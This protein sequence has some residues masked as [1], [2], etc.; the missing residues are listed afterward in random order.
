[1]PRGSLIVALDFSACDEEEF[2][3]WYDTE[4]FPERECV[5]GFGLCE[6][7]ISIANPKISVATYDLDSFDVLK[8]PAY[9]AISGE[10]LSPWSRR[11]G[12]KYKRLLRSDGDQASHGN[13]EAR[14]G[15]GGLLINAMNVAPEHEADFNAW[16]DQ[17]HLSALAKV[18][19]TILARRFKSRSGSHKYLAVYHLTSPDVVTMDA[20]K[21]AVNTPWTARVRHTYLDHF[22]VVLRPYKRGA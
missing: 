20:W 9:Q 6:R 5:E 18:P 4:H 17:E 16:Y 14:V 11:L 8:S 7:W 12:Q 15:A 2:H 10:N 19:G 21:E 22:R 1:M 13:L 3:D